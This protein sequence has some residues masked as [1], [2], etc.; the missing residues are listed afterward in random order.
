MF[1]SFVFLHLSSRIYIC[2][3]NFIQ[4]ALKITL[5]ILNVKC[6]IRK[7]ILGL[8]LSLFQRYCFDFKK[9]GRACGKACLMI[10]MNFKNKLKMKISYTK[11]FANKILKSATKVNF[12]K[13]L[14][15]SRF[16]YGNIHFVENRRNSMF[17]LTKVTFCLKKSKWNK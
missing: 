16:M 6:M 5:H 8:S 11:S 9:R 17:T 1:V 15:L 3:R 2:I 12:L 4:L 7:K 14:R 13:Y 10:F